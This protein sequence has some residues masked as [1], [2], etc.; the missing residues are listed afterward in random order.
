VIYNSRVPQ[1]GVLQ[2]NTCVNNQHMAYPGH[3]TNC[4]GMES[5]L[6]LQAHPIMTE[7][8]ASCIILNTVYLS[9]TANEI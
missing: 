5:K 4:I 6:E 1:R 3:H 2:S 7:R 8:Y 9:N